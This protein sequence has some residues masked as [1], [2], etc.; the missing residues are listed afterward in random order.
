MDE[1]QIARFWSRVEKTDG[2]WVWTRG[3]LNDGYGVAW[4][5]IHS[6]LAHRVSWFLTHGSWPTDCLCHRCDNRLCV[7]PAHLFEGSRADNLADMRAKGREAPMPK[8]QVGERHHKTRLTAADVRHFR[9]LA[10]LTSCANIARWYGMSRSTM[11]CVVRGRSWRH[12]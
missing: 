8:T 4:D 1:K 10:N 12:A 2:C 6:R 9:A 7:N 11:V 5:G 3:A